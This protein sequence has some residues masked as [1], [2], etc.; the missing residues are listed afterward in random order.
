MRVGI[1]A[2]NLRTGGGVTHLA[3]LLGAGS[4]EGHGIEHVVVWG[5]RDTLAQL[6]QAPWLTAAHVPALDGTLPARQ[7]W[8]RFHLERAAR[9]AVDLLFAPGGAYSGS[10]RPFVTM[11]RNLLPF[12]AAERRRYGV[13]W[14]HAK[15]VLL[16]RAQRS[17]FRRAAGV[18]FLNDYA[19]RA[20]LHDT[21]PLPGA[22]AIVPH[23]VDEVFRQAPR[24]ARPVAAVSPATPFRVLYVSN[25]EVYKHQWHVV[26]AIARLREEGVPVRLDLIGA[27]RADASRRLRA[28][29]AR[30]D[31]HGTFVSWLGAVAHRDLPAHYRA[32]DLFAYASSCENMPNILLEAMASGLPIACSRLGPM[33]GMLQDAGEYF[34]PTDA[35]SIATAVRSLLADPSR[36]EALAASAAAR[37][38][39]YSWTRCA[40]DTWAFLAAVHARP[41]RA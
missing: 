34:E 19:R 37:A 30:V 14:M 11:S 1:D 7:W 40:S 2:S 3:A 15:L 17:A 23:G 36:R 6:P 8:Q 29:I 41:V 31:P 5:G 13:S 12:E 9:K 20:V 16:R 18:I 4:P 21:G 26:D 24:P 38:A 39:E 28:E 35:G 33:P 32:A 27:G 10:F 22:T 25:V